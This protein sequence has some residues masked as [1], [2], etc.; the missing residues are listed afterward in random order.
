MT[1]LTRSANHKVGLAMRLIAVQP[2]SSSNSTRIQTSFHSLLLSSDLECFFPLDVI[3]IVL[4]FL[5]ETRLHLTRCLLIDF[6]SD[7]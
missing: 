5:Q 6:S 7:V 2:I 1:Q 3:L 4:E